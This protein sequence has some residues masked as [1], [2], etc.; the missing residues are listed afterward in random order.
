M[1]CEICGTNRNLDQHHVESR[2]MGGSKDP[3]VNADDN[4][5]TLC[6]SCHRNIHEGG[7][8]LQCSASMFRVIDRRTGEQVMRR[9]RSPTFNPSSFLQLL[10]VIDRSLSEAPTLVAYLDDDQ[11]V[12]FRPPFSTRPSSEVCT[13]RVHLRLSR[14]ASRSVSVRLRNML[15][16]GGFSLQVKTRMRVTVKPEKTSTLTLSLSKS[17][18]GTS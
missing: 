16:S 11:L 5:I 7:W 9:M 18:V 13:V 4:L 6:R 14:V 17:Q 1:N 12:E 15:S 2:G 10:N 8:E 3:V